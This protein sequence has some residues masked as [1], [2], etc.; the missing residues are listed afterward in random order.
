MPANKKHL[1]KSPWIRTLK[2]LAGTIGGYTVMFSFHLFLSK[3]LPREA[4]VVTS[5]ITGYLLWGI[6]LL[7]AFIADN[8]WKLWLLYIGLTLLFSMLFLTSF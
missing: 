2:I 3:I 4:V 6:L 8:V 7:W 5:F 1:T